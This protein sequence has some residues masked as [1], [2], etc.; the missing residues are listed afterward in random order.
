MPAPIV[1][2]A[3]PK[4]LVIIILLA[5]IA[6]GLMMLLAYYKGVDDTRKT[7]N[8]FVNSKAADFSKYK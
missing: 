2:I 5:V 6:S 3:D 8:G 7:V 1:A 4:D